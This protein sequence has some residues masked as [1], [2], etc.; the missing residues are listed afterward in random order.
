MCLSLS[1]CPRVCVA[2]GWRGT[3]NRKYGAM[4][5]A[6]GPAR[7]WNADHHDLPSL[8][9]QSA[10]AGGGPNPRP[11]LAIMVPTTIR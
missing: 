3:C 2:A 10:W 6:G 1:V 8:S 11:D 5:L 7:R 9:G 4:P